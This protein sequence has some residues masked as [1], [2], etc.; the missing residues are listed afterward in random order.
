[1]TVRI[2]NKF[3]EHAEALFEKTAKDAEDR[4]TSYKRLAKNS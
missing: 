1:M 3:P 2:M 4:R